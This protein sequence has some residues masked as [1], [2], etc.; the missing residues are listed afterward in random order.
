MIF[1][2]IWVSCL[3]CVAL[4]RGMLQHSPILSIGGQAYPELPGLVDVHFMVLVDFIVKGS[5]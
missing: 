5:S 2:E 1:C 4:G 3:S